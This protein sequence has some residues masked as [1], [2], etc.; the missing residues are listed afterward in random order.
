MVNIP[1]KQI[2]LNSPHYW[3]Q[4]VFGLRIGDFH[5]DMLEHIETGSRQLL[6]APRGFGK[7]KIA[8]AMIAWRIIKDPDLRVL[9][10]SA[11]YSKAV[12]FMGGIKRALESDYIKQHFGDIR[13]SKWSDNAITIKGRTA[14]HV[15]PSLMA[16]GGGS[17]SIVGLHEELLIL[18]DVTDYDTARSPVKNDRLLEWYQTS[19]LPT[20]M[21]GGQIIALG[22]RYAANDIY[23]SLIHMDY[24]TRIFPAINNDGTSLCSWIRPVDDVRSADGSI[25]MEGLNT[26]KKNLGSI[27]FALQFLNDTTPLSENNVIKSGWLKYYDTSPHTMKDVIVSVDP[28]IGLK[29]ENDYSAIGVW[30]RDENNNIYLLESINRRMTFNSTIT[31][32]DELIS[33]YRPEHVV[34]EDVAYQKALIQELKRKCGHTS[35]IGVN[36]PTDKRARLIN[37]SSYFENGMVY[38]RH[39]ETTLIDQL[40]YFPAQFDDQVDQ[41]TLALGWYKEHEANM[42]TII[43]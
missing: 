19:V 11:S 31:T 40:L 5:S 24:N 35:I 28:A 41:T 1:T 23:N 16:I 20:L 37:V 42:G 22:T 33:R 8:Q 13:G 6:L 14:N 10:V 27:I 15:E 38:I 43:F 29:S 2:L 18:D 21:P 3:A 30:C 7:S 12:L 26:I 36:P 9:L 39:A 34:V 25:E 32:V 4:E 17:S